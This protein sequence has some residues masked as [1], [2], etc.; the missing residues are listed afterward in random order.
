[1][2]FVN[3]LPVLKDNKTAKVIK[4]SR[5]AFAEL[6]DA[7]VRTSEV[8]DDVEDSQAEDDH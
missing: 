5:K 1:L 4:H 2:S 3:N 7:R 8:K 6:L